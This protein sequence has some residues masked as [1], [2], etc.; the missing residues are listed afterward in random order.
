LIQKTVINYIICVGFILLNF[1][2]LIVVYKMM[3]NLGP[4]LHEID[5]LIKLIKLPSDHPK[6]QRSILFYKLFKTNEFKD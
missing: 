6:R 1:L 3:L 5:E 4:K 2:N